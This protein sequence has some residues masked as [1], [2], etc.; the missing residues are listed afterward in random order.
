MK[1]TILM[2]LFAAMTLLHSC[3]EE[4]LVDESLVEMELSAVT[5]SPTEGDIVAID[6][7]KSRTFVVEDDKYENGVGTKWRTKEVIGVYSSYSKNAKFTSTN[8]SDSENVSFK[9]SMWGTPKY[10]YYPYNEANNGIS[11]TAVKQTMP[12]YH[13]YHSTFKDLV[14]DFRAGVLDSRTWTSSTFT[15][16]RL[17][18]IMKISI[19]ATGT[20][21]ENSDLRSISMKVNNKRKISGDFTI[22]LQRQT[23]ALGDFEDT[24][25]S[26][27]VKW[28]DEP[29][30]M[31]G[32]TYTAYVTA[33]PS[34]KE[35]DEI[36]FT[37][38]TNKQTATFVSKASATHIANEVYAYPLVL[39][40]FDMEVEG[41]NQGTEETPV[42]PTEFKILSMKFEAALNPG[43]I[44]TR[45]F[46]V[47]NS[48]NA[49]VKNTTE[50]ICTIDQENKKIKLN[51]PYLNNRK[52]IPTIEATEGAELAIEEGIFT[53]G[54][55]E[56]D[57]S[58][59]KQIAVGTNNDN[60]TLYDVELTNSGL[61]VVVV[62]Q[63]T[64]L[65][66]SETGDYQ[67]ASKTWYEAT[68]T[69][70]QPKESDWEMTDGDDNFMIYNA[71][72]TSALTDKNGAI[73]N[74]PILAS[75]RVRG[76]VTQQMPKKAFAV[77]LD[78]KHGIFMNDNDASNDMEAHKRWVLLANWK[79]RTLMRNAV[80]FG[81]ADVFKNTLSGGMAWNPSGQFV[82]LVY[83]GVHVGTY[84]LC[85]QIKIDGNRLDI[86]DPYDKDDAY[87][88]NP[89]DYGYLL[90]CDDAYDENQVFT[91]A[92]YIPF[93][94]KDDGTD[95]MLTYAQNFVRGIEDNLYA[96]N[97]D[98]A[99]EK[100][101]LTSLVDYWLIQELMMNSEMKHPKS[102]YMYINEG[103]FYAGPIWDF[104]WN[105]LPTS[106]SYSE[107][108][109]SYT[110]SMIAKAKCYHKNSGYPTAPMDDSSLF[111][112]SDKNYFWYPMLVKDATFKAL[113]AERWNAVKGALQS[114]VSTQIPAMKAKIATSE[115]VNN[116]MWPITV[117]SGWS[118]NTYGMGGGACGDESKTFE[119]AV[120]TMITTLTNRIN[121]MNYVST[122]TW[123]SISYST[124]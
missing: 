115:A 93:L 100:M 55:D 77:K 67:K 85:E 19:D 81:I 16:N 57:F 47:D 94:F 92:N 109:Y 120:S 101:D 80:A 107:E 89:A 73:V 45:S 121:G 21:L 62:N 17:V 102:V 59:F 70:W 69:G 53:S 61:P 98:A 79:D 76:N 99:Y 39:K 31:T 4:S 6:L 51:L 37:V 63:K 86:N 14:G 60:M 110:A 105:T 34:I 35:G 40:N 111:S 97:Y 11:A 5:E 42:T 44:L 30:M 50:A 18:S 123:P 33:L 74:E 26:I 13:S 91:T 28:S 25:D 71:D 22:N 15:F 83:N 124:K 113:A 65:V 106:T 87:S 43:K 52:L 7:P 108:G 103:K 54:V 3:Q 117:K 27:S 95:E 41:D 64:G 88:G 49:T 9:G 24:N 82:E 10:A 66:T 116:K 36:V 29:T 84:Y 38:K 1:K 12:V 46:S 112:P 72:G 58:A 122:Q 48:G 78:K 56:I 119:D 8:K 96:G 2:S 20:A 104:D 75:T 114:Y 68:G 90:E 23:I 32:R 118:T